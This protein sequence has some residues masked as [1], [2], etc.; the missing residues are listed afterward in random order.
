MPSKKIRAT[1]EPGCIYHIY[2]RG[3]NYQDVFFEEEDYSMFLNNIKLYLLDY[4]SL[5]AFA[6]LPNHYHLLLRVNDDI[7]RLVFSRQFSKVIIKYTSCI[8]YRNNRKGNL[9]QC[10]FRR[11]KVENED[12]L[13]RLVYYIHHNPQKHGLVAD[14]RLYKLTSY[15][16]Y[17]SGNPT[18]LSKRESIS[19]FG[20]TEEFISYHNYLQDVSS[21]NK[22]TLED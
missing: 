17:L 18:N 20:S 12:Y 15:K 8:N 9:F 16:S 14:F 19:W 7:E 4:C 6:L 2:N 3:H 5:N 13:K 1:I 10:R 21:L 11:I 22:L